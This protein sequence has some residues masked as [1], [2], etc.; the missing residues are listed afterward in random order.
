MFAGPNGSGK[1]SLYERLITE[2]HFTHT[3]YINAD[4]IQSEL[5]GGGTISFPFDSTESFFQALNAGAFV[6]EELL[7]P[8]ETA[9]LTGSLRDG[10]RLKPGARCESYLAAGIADAL[11]SLFLNENQ[12][13]AF[14]TVMSHES[15]L[16]LLR[17]AKSLGYRNYL[18]YVSTG[19]PE[20]NLRRVEQ[21]VKGGG[22]DVPADLV[23]ARFYRSMKLV[24]EAIQLCDRAYLLDNSGETIKL[25]A[26]TDGN[27][28]HL[29]SPRIP[30]WVQ[31]LLPNWDS[32]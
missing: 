30:G 10:L 8:A 13:F 15:K 7:T 5:N 25:V 31:D 24:P 19:D 26:W 2:N 14:E 20:I 6:K 29:A 16:E 11:R 4:R 12:S 18:Y 17:H 28:L 22:H 21:R 32:A 23:R 1:T 27:N 3:Y 9:S